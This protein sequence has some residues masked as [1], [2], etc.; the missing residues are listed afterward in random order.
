M[1]GYQI[2]SYIYIFF[3]SLIFVKAGIIYNISKVKCI[4]E[5]NLF[6]TNIEKKKKRNRDDECAFINKNCLHALKSN[7]L[8]GRSDKIR[9][10][11]R[12]HIYKFSAESRNKLQYDE[13]Y[14]S[15]RSFVTSLVA[16]D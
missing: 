2:D 10:Y 11:N 5:E 6:A 1:S 7:N 15:D 8:N 16:I 4:L 12:V 9:Q 14:K 3:H 13:F